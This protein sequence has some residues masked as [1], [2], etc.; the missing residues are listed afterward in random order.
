VSQGFSV[1]TASLSAG[2]QDIATL[3]S[4]CEKI[5]SDGVSALEGMASA[6]AGHPALQATLLDAA[7]QGTKTFLDIGAAYEYV[8]TNLQATAGTYAST[9]TGHHQQDRRDP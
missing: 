3:L 2:S 5:G 8:G 4:A 9:E 1:S 7:E 6:A